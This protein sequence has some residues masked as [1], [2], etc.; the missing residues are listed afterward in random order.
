[1][2][3][4][5]HDWSTPGAP[6]P[7]P[8]V[9]VAAA[10]YVQSAPLGGAAP[11]TPPVAPR[12]DRHELVLTGLLF[13]AA[14]VAGAAS[15]M[16]WRDYAYRYGTRLEETGW[17][18]ADGSLGRGWITVLLAVCIAVSGVLIAA[19]K[20]RLGRT[21][22]TLSGTGLVLVAIGEWGLGAGAARTGP[23]TGIWV[24]LVVGVVVVVAVG[25]LGTR[26]PSPSA[27]VDG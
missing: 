8:P 25:A 20:V 10:Q 24:E 3:P 4:P 22:A 16:P 7:N 2:Q 6:A 1:M 17:M 13:V 21:L 5:D 18:E 27:P 23:G 12:S 26:G 9:P 14:L 19:E 15:L 11:V